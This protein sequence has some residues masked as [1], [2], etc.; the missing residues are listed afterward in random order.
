MRAIRIPQLPHC[1]LQFSSTLRAYVP[2]CLRDYVPTCLRA[3]VSSWSKNLQKGN[4]VSVHIFAWKRD[5]I[6]MTRHRIPARESES[7]SSCP[8]ESWL[9]R[10]V[11]GIPFGTD[12]CRPIVSGLGRQSNA[13]DSATNRTGPSKP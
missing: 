11:P 12:F 1:L 8:G 3:F 9:S 5:A 13:V 4:P 6:N 2:S 10:W 7:D